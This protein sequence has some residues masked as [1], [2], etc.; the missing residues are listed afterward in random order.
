MATWK[1]TVDFTDED[2]EED[3]EEIEVEANTEELAI[4]K[5]ENQVEAM[6]EVETID[7]VDA[8]PW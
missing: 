6:H 7:R 3:F 5:A 4:E 8:R 2:G 1:V